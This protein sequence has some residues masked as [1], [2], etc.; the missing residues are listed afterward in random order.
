MSG[1]N[2]AECGDST[3]MMMTGMSQSEGRE[4]NERKYA[5]SGEPH[6]GSV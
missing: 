1:G 5:D 6:G 4:R 3:V 2:F